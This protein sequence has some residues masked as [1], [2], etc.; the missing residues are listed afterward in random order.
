[1]SQI[2]TFCFST[3]GMCDNLICCALICTSL[4]RGS[5]GGARKRAL[6]I[7]ARDEVH[8]KHVKSRCVTETSSQE[9]SAIKTTLDN[10]QNAQRQRHVQ[11]DQR[12]WSSI[13]THAMANGG[14]NLRVRF[15]SQL[16]SAPSEDTI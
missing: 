14:L 15:E 16:Q 5:R 4:C 11:K 6:G 12:F 13:T 7:V 3:R 1:M 8:V 2:N 9:T 10:V